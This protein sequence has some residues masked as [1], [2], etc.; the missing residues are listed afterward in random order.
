MKKSIAIL[1]AAVMVLSFAACGK[2]NQ[3]VGSWTD[4]THT[5]TFRKDGTGSFSEFGE[6][7]SMSYRISGN[8]LT[9]YFG[10]ETDEYLFEIKGKTLK[11]FISGFDDDPYFTLKKK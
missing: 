2:K 8:K 10:S 3:I 6:T 9:V 4:G 1:L 11:M 5:W 7:M